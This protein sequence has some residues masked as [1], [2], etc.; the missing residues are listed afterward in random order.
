MEFQVFSGVRESRHCL[1]IV[2]DLICWNSGSFVSVADYRA[3]GAVY[4]VCV[5][6]ELDDT[7][8]IRS[9]CSDGTF[10][11]VAEESGR[12]SV[13]RPKSTGVVRPLFSTVTVG[14][15]SS[16]SAYMGAEGATLIGIGSTFSV[17]LLEWVGEQLRVL[18]TKQMAYPVCDVAAMNATVPVLAVA[19]LSAPP[20]TIAADGAVSRGSAHVSA[21]CAHGS[22]LYT[23]G[24]DLLGRDHRLKVLAR[25]GGR[26]SCLSA[27]DSAVYTVDDANLYS[28][29][30]EARHVPLFRDHEAVPVTA[31]CAGPNFVVAT[32]GGILASYT[33]LLSLISHR[34]HHTEQI[35]DCAFF[36]QLV[37]SSMDCS[38]LGWGGECATRLLAHGSAVFAVDN[39]KDGIVVGGDEPHALVLRHTEHSRRLCGL[40]VKEG[41]PKSAAGQALHLA[42]KPV[43]SQ[44]EADAGLPPAFS[45]PG[46][47]ALRHALVDLPDRRTPEASL[48]GGLMWCPSALG[49]H[50]VVVDGV[51]CAGS[52]AVCFGPSDR[53]DE[54]F[55]AVWRDGVKERK[56]FPGKTT[57]R[58]LAADTD[59]KQVLALSS[60]GSLVLD[61]TLLGKTR[62]VLESA[63]VSLG[64]HP[65]AIALSRDSLLRF[66]GEWTSEPRGNVVAVAAHD[67]KFY[68]VHRE[69][70]GTVVRSACSECIVPLVAAH[71]RLKVIG[72]RCC[73]LLGRSAI[74]L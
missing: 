59:G 68:T 73:L 5:P 20:V 24:A 56:V 21:L 17:S 14:P 66:D 13:F 65:L 22:A 18:F 28:F 42:A 48:V 15:V 72:N 55:A 61:G 33:P 10:L 69:S 36:E 52:V 7:P 8:I 64:A 51:V 1:A 31:V 25:L 12:I 27:S 37:T 58:V 43:Q 26:M 49:P 57:R 53:K 16:L 67:D 41:L 44:E 40:E 23:A 30:S 50:P 70:R 62:G 47:G 54:A 38:L 63:S 71:T 74:I 45:V 4:G 32:Y 2:G 11:F 39:Y 35:T 34:A 19:M 46:E 29:G 9:I 3:L 6:T 60:S